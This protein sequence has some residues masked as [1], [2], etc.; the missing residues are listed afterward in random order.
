LGFEKKFRFWGQGGRRFREIHVKAF[1]LKRLGWGERVRG[2]TF[3]QNINKWEV[4]TMLKKGLFVGGGL[5]LLLVLLF[6]G[7]T[8][9]S[10]VATV[11]QQAKEA[12]AD[13][14]P[15]EF[16]LDRARNMIKGLEPE[17][18]NHK[19]DIALEEG[20]VADLEDQIELD[21]GKLAKRWSDIE[22]MRADL[23]KGETTF[24]YASG[25][26][27]AKQVEADLAI[28]FD[29]YTTSESTVEQNRKVLEIRKKTLTAA[30]EKLKAL[31]AA[32]GKLELQ[33]EELEAKL[34]MVE[35]AQTASE[36]NIDD[37]QLAK[38]RDLLD[39][40][41]ARIDVDARLVNADDLGVGEIQLHE[42]AENASILERIADY[43]AKKDQSETFVD[44][45]PEE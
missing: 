12:V 34:K 7:R 40:I 39:E 24:T 38:T 8:M 37:S 35:V 22:H 45:K 2:S 23:S 11:G 17:I 15:V 41:E 43:Q 1:G 44:V 13:K 32:K 42:P 6:G 20:R 29:H 28:K 33:V 18:I 27:T 16:Q 25:T 14:V 19:R 4:G 3:V 26:Y 10:Y 30:Q 9:W 36:L 21:E 5:L 31:I